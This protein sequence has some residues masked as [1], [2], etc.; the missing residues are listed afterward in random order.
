[1]EEISAAHIPEVSPPKRGEDGFN[2]SGKKP[3]LSGHAGTL[4]DPVGPID[5]KAKRGRKEQEEAISKH[6]NFRLHLP[7]DGTCV[8]GGDNGSQSDF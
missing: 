7:C 2:T 3:L 5:R 4:S 6:G 1:M 8:K